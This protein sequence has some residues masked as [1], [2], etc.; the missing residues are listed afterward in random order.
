MPRGLRV[1]CLVAGLGVLFGS[2]EAAAKETTSKDGRSRVSLRFAVER[3]YGE[4]ER[5]YEGHWG[6]G[7]YG[8]AKFA[9]TA[10]ESLWGWRVRGELL[11]GQVGGFFGKV[12]PWFELNDP[13]EHSMQ[14]AGN[15]LRFST[16]PLL[17]GV[18][19][20]VEYRFLK[21]RI[22]FSG[23]LGLGTMNERLSTGPSLLVEPTSVRFSVNGNASAGLR[24]PLGPIFA[25]GA[26]LAAEY[27]VFLEASRFSGGLFLEAGFE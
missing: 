25:L 15:E 12:G 5:N 14:V 26:T 17:I 8:E 18:N 10:Q 24:V 21:E 22:F 1:L 9:G 16:A 3:S 27:H 23:G 20:A 7:S 13:K 11:F 4:W 19:A 2:G 6:G